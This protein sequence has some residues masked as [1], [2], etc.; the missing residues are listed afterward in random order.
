MP[1]PKILE[2]IFSASA[3][4]A[5]STAHHGRRLADGAHDVLISGAPADIP[6]QAVSNLVVGWRA[7]VLEQV[8]RGQNHARGAEAALETVLVPERLLNRVE[9]TILSKTFDCGNRAAV[10]LN[11]KTRARLDGHTIQQNR[12]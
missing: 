11:G 5:L 12:A 7:V 2:D 9:H 4:S 1:D 3:S 6:F 8:V 10:G